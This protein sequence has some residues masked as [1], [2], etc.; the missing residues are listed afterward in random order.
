MQ[1]RYNNSYV[2]Y[3]DL[4]KKYINL[5]AYTYTEDLTKSNFSIKKQSYTKFRLCKNEDYKKVNITKYVEQVKS[6]TGQFSEICV[7]S[8]KKMSLLR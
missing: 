7:D 3:N 4:I 8:Y 5:T 1:L 6:I 2:V